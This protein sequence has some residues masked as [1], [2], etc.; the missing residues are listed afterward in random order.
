[1]K[2]LKCNNEINQNS[3]FCVFCGEKVENNSDMSNLASSFSS[4]LNYTNYNFENNYKKQTFF[5]FKE[6]EMYIKETL[7]DEKMREYKFKY[8]DITRYSV[9]PNSNG[10]YELSFYSNDRK[11]EKIENG[12]NN[13]ES[14]ISIKIKMNVL[15]SSLSSDFMVK[16]DQNDIKNVIYNNTPLRSE[17]DFIQETK[18]NIYELYNNTSDDKFGVVYIEGP[19]KDLKE[20][21]ISLNSIPFIAIHTSRQE[22]KLKDDGLY[23]ESIARPYWVNNNTIGFR[24]PYG[25]WTIGYSY[26]ATSYSS[27]NSINGIDYMSGPESI[28]I[29]VNINEPEIRLKTKVGLFKNKLKKK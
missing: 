28:D 24:I 8:T 14:F 13:F 5:E 7:I 12:K 20:Y 4:N 3:N 26:E 23:E 11:I 21:W 29:N 2:C 10:F 1:M 19:K 17:L 25:N 16:E 18:K 27:I 6:T 9:V 22:K 15:N